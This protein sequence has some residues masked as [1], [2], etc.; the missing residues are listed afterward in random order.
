VGG[1]AA[2]TASEAVTEASA[3]ETSY[4]NAGEQKQSQG[5]P[6]GD[7]GDTEQSR[8]DG[9]PE[10]HDGAAEDDDERGSNE[11][12]HADVGGDVRGTVPVRET[13][14]FVKALVKIHHD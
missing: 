12:G 8:H 11:E 9:I 3:M 6:E 13:G 2:E 4:E 14:A 10:V 7:V 1:V 5:M